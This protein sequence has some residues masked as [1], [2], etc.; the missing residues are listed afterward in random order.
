M[1]DSDNI[2][3]FPIRSQYF[4]MNENKDSLEIELYLGQMYIGSFH[5]ELYKIIRQY[6]AN[7][8]G[9]NQLKNTGLSPETREGLTTLLA[10]LR[11]SLDKIESEFLV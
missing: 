8:E 6:V 4:F 1:I 9:I 2:L 7:N 10:T 5:T 3:T 11:A